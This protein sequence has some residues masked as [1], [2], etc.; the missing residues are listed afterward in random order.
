ME[1]IIKDNDLNSAILRYIC[2]CHASGDYRALQQL[3]IEADTLDLIKSMTV[4]EAIYTSG[5]RASFVKHLRVDNTILANRLQHARREA[6]QQ[7]Q[8]TDLVVHGAPIKLIQELTGM[9]AKEFAARRRLGGVGHRG[10]TEIPSEEIE[11][12]IT[13]A[14]KALDMR[15]DLSADDW[16]ELARVTNQPIRIIYK[17]IKGE[18]DD[19]NDSIH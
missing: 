3:G 1:A 9:S 8:I 19:S 18:E 10:R 17:V 12:V 6:L 15:S 4:H 13:E 14:W 11:E 5:M 7:Q 16:I 2:Q